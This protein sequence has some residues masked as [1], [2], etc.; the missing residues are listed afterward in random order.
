MKG[1][2]C[3]WSCSSAGPC[4]ALCPSFYRQALVPLGAGWVLWEG[5]TQ[6]LCAGQGRLCWEAD[7]EENGFVAVITSQAYLVRKLLNARA[8]CQHD[9]TV[10]LSCQWFT[11]CSVWEF[12][13]EFSSP[14]GMLWWM[15]DVW[16][17]NFVK[18]P[19][20][21]MVTTAPSLWA[22][23]FS[24]SFVLGFCGTLTLRKTQPLSWV[25]VDQSE[26]KKRRAWR[27]KTDFLL[28][29]SNRVFCW[30]RMGG[31]NK[32]MNVLS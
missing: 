27:Y 5:H 21:F 9:T 16:R 10:L 28:F 20:D 29:Y 7:A 22:S 2:L 15:N 23:M 18:H 14:L 17:V 4:S 1:S 25:S 12:C 6:L 19:P 32:E 30:I 24:L 8:S 13:V 31:R 26:S 3:C 11:N